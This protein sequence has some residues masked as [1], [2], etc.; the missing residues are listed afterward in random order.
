MAVAAPFME[1]E[2]AVVSMEAEGVAG[3]TAEGEVIPATACREALAAA[4]G[5][6]EPACRAAVPTAADFEAAPL[7]MVIVPERQQAAE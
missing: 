4:P 5:T 2:G 6:T 3:F 7:R 1:A